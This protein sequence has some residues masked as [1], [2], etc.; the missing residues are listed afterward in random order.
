MSLIDIPVEYTEGRSGILCS[1]SLCYLLYM[2][3]RIVYSQTGSHEIF[4]ASLF[5]LLILSVPKNLLMNSVELLLAAKE[6]METGQYNEAIDLATKAHEAGETQI[7]VSQI[8][9]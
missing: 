9:A 6:K 5:Q 1:L 7:A 8:L 2:L 3:V 4:F